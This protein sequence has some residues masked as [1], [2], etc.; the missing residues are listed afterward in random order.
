MARLKVN[1]YVVNP[2]TGA[3]VLVMAGSDLPEWAAGAV[4]GHAL[5]ED[6]EGEQ[7]KPD[8]DGE[9]D[10]E[11]EQPKPTSKPRRRTRG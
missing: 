6:G 4:G 7:P 1:V 3:L 11:G 10:G 9:P 5:E 8:A 2:S